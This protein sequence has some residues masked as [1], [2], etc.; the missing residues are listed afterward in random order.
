MTQATLI[1]A[2]CHRHRG[3]WRRKRRE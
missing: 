3:Q 2:G 1:A